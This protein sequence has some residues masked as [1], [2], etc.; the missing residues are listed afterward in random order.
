MSH[1]TASVEAPPAAPA[2]AVPDSGPRRRTLVSVAVGL[3]VLY[4]AMMAT[5]GD[6]AYDAKLADVSDHYGDISQTVNQVTSYV[7]MVLVALVL[8]F[9]AALRNAVRR[10]GATWLGDVVLL[11]FGGLAAT[12]ASW[13]VIDAA[14]WRAVDH[15]D[16]SAIRAMLTMGD[17]AFLPLMA[18]MI[19]I[20][21][22]AGLA[23]LAS[24]N[25]PRWLA[26]VS[27]VVGLLAPL[28]PLGFVGAVLLPIWAVAVA[29]TV[30]I[31][32][33]A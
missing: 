15:G 17:V 21:V 32:E 2:P 14:L 27:I 28:G 23:G 1:V 9:G 7:G 22:G 20:Y 6:F 11:G 30:R 12:F 24:G 16:D 10:A 19:A 26:V 29:L 13:G 4:A 8:F 31:D 5:G 18:S 33:S 3:L 25:L